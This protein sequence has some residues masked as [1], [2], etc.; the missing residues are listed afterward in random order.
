MRER[1]ECR[2]RKNECKPPLLTH[3]RLAGGKGGGKRVCLKTQMTPVSPPQFPS[4]SLALCF[5]ILRG[6]TPTPPP[7]IQILGVCLP[8]THCHLLQ[9]PRLYPPDLVRLEIPC[10]RVVCDGSSSRGKRKRSVAHGCENRLR[11]GVRPPSPLETSS[12]RGPRVRF[13]DTAFRM[14]A[15]LLPMGW[16]T[17]PQR[18]WRLTRGVPS[19]YFKRPGVQT[20]RP[21]LT[22]TRLPRDAPC[23]PRWLLD[24]WL[25]VPDLTKD[26]GTKSGEKRRKKKGGE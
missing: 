18:C 24:V 1:G 25:L 26:R 11:V 7:Q 17:M 12:S 16:F 4:H 6:T 19:Q 2:H 22:S 8:A 9:T 15:G 14:T 21:T 13:G 10:L 23:G 5:Q 3:G 20:A